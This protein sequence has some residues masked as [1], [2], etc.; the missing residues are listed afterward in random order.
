KEGDQLQFIV[1]KNVW[2]ASR[3]APLENCD[4][5]L[6]GTTVGPGFEFEDFTLGQ[7][8]D[9]KREFSEHSQIIELLTRTSDETK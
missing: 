3:L 9:L 4:W 5:A 8:S 2:Q 1:E 6:L 7:R